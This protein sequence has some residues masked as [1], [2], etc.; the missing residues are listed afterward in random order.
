MNFQLCCIGCLILLLSCG[1]SNDFLDILAVAK[2]WQIN[3][4]KI[5]VSR[6]LKKMEK[7][8][9]RI[10]SPFF[11]LCVC[12]CFLCVCVCVVVVVFGVGGGGG[13]EEGR[14]LFVF[15]F[16]FFNELLHYCSMPFSRL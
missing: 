7:Q 4:Q 10:M 6:K 3:T 14:F 9:T 15:V 5:S 16:F 13:G 8:K 2:R 12:F 1:R 11:F